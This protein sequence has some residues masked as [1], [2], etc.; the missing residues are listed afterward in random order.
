MLENNE[1]DKFGKR[2]YGSEKNV[3]KREHESITSINHRK[4]VERKKTILHINAL[5]RTGNIEHMGECVKP[6]KLSDALMC[7]GIWSK[8]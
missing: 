6:F 2:G 5:A 8:E 1:S 4:L 7:I 3:A